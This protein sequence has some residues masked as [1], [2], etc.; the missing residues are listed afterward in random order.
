MKSW[1]IDARQGR[2]GRSVKLVMPPDSVTELSLGAGPARNPDPVPP[3][4]LTILL[5]AAPLTFGRYATSMIDSSDQVMLLGALSALLEHVPA[6]SVRLVVFNLEQQKELLRR[7]GFTLQSI[8]EVARTLNELKLGKVDVQVLQSRTGHV[9]L[10]ERLINGELRAEPP[11]DVVIFLGPRERFHDKVP[12]QALEPHSGASARFLYL[13]CH[14]PRQ[15]QGGLAGDQ[16][17]DVASGVLLDQTP[18]WDGVK[19]NP[20]VSKTSAGPDPGFSRAPA[21]YRQSGGRRVERQDPGHRLPQSIRQGDP[22]D[23]AARRPVTIH[24]YIPVRVRYSCTFR[25]PPG[26]LGRP[27]SPMVCPRGL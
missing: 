26:H 11:P 14:S 21:R 6:L 16:G 5:D 17:S 2:A 18:A 20:H 12:A 24:V 23:R 22:G 25:V 27:N 10:L 8:D 7:D 13:A 1:A 3:Q 19:D 9:D 15:V 4:R